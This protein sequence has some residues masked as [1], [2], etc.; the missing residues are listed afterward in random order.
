MAIYL[1]ELTNKQLEM[2][3]DT[4]NGF[5]GR[6]AKLRRYYNGQ[7]SIV[8]KNESYADGIK[9][10][11]NVT[12]WVEYIV[13]QYV[14]AITEHQI[15]V[16]ESAEET[17]EEVVDTAV[18]QD[19]IDEIRRNAARFGEA[20]MN[21]RLRR[22]A[23]LY[24]RG[25][26]LH[27][28]DPE[29]KAPRFTVYDPDEFVLL[30]DENDEIE[31][32]LRVVEFEEGSL[33]KGRILDTNVMV[34][35]GFDR[36][37]KVVY[38]RQ[39]SDTGKQEWI[40]TEGPTPHYYDAVPV[41][42]WYVKPNQGS[43]I[44]DALIGQNDEYNEI[45]S[46]SGD[47]IRREVESLMKITGV[48]MVQVRENADAIKALRILALP[49]ADSDAEYL[50]RNFDTTR[51][52]VRLQ[53]CREQIHIMGRIPDVSQIV[54][55]T[56]ATSGIALKLMFTPMQQAAEA[57]INNLEIAF[58]KRIEL[59][60]KMWQR[61]N[62]PFTLDQFFVQTQFKIPV[63]RIE[64]W[65]NIAN[66][67]GQLSHRTRLEL[68][69]DIEDPEAELDAIRREKEQAVED[70]RILEPNLG[71]ENSMSE[72]NDAVVART[73]QSVSTN[74]EQ[75]LMKFSEQITQATTAALKRT[76]LGKENTP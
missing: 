62:M 39:R 72:N 9:K 8:G 11:E 59:F 50:T 65:Q 36:R 34:M 48:D 1:T 58:R 10:S 43:I 74:L 31:L 20:A 25:I 46:S 73:A 26:E 5:R 42:E 40:V 14:G 15:T 4:W 13:D 67:D 18:V 56:G 61:A 33:Y 35:Y 54:G 29:E 28:W 22:S 76:N 27:W 51:V 68:L 66:L 55:S 23:L 52:D 38:E 44:S 60:T 30:K 21:L 47:D 75:V 64:E 32:A 3:W 71:E 17:E 69:T 70:K 24:G 41:V 12:N 53:R 19:T 49:D 7:H 2:L 63:N 16:Q 37:S 45:D 57:Y 6:T